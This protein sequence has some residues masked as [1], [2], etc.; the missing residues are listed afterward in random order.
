MPQHK[1]DPERDADPFL[2]SV[3]P[4]WLHRAL[5]LLL[6]IWR[7][8]QVQL[9]PEHVD[10]QPIRCYAAGAA[11]FMLHGLWV[12]FSALHILLLLSCTLLAIFLNT[13]QRWAHYASIL[14]CGVAVVAVPLGNAA[15]R[16]YGGNAPRGEWLYTLAVFCLALGAACSVVCLWYQRD[17]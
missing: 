15:L 12:G 17:S 14:V 7:W 10:Q 4:K 9:S 13:R 5:Q 16:I 2:G 8:L 3:L 1:P 6:P 11:L